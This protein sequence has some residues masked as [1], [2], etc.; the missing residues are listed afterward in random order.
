M[1]AREQCILVVG[2]VGSQKTEYAVRIDPHRQQADQTAVM[3]GTDQEWLGN[4]LAVCL[5]I[6]F[7]PGRVQEG[8]TILT[9]P[10][11]PPRVGPLGR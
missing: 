2:W 9:S 8:I 1:F 5:D 6:S 4:P 10:Q 7:I 11:L 3:P